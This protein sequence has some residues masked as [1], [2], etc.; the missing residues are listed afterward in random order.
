[1]NI[2]TTTLL[3]ALLGDHPQEVINNPNFISVNKKRKANYSY[4]I[5]SSGRKFKNNMH[6][7]TKSYYN[8]D[9]SHFKRSKRGNH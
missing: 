9:M 1:M 7:Y 6:N 5:K 3:A 4:D 8:K 2:L